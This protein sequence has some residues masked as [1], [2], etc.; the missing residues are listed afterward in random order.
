MSNIEIS[1][2]KYRM[3]RGNVVLFYDI[4]IDELTIANKGDLKGLQDL[5]DLNI[6]SKELLK[7]IEENE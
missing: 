6:L 5:K 2:T 4:E 1:K 7:Y 3:D